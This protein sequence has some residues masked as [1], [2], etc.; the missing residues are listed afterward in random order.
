[1]GIISALLFFF[2]ERNLLE[3]K[4]QELEQ[5]L[6]EQTARADAIISQWQERD[7]EWSDICNREMETSEMW[8]F[9]TLDK[10]QR[11]PRRE[12]VLLGKEKPS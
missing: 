5:E 9:Y 3:E 10:H 7:K 4:L 6:A 1:M 11:Q 2:G 12:R 8:K